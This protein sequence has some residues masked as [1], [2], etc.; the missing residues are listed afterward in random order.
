MPKTFAVLRVGGE[1]PRVPLV[2]KEE[3]KKAL[4]PNTEKRLRQH[5]ETPFGNGVRNGVR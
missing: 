4:L 3:I 2:V 5:Q 1:V